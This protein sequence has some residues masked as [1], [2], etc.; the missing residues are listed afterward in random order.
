MSD[1]RALLQ[2][3]RL[4]TEEQVLNGRAGIITDHHNKLLPRLTADKTAATSS[5]RRSVEKTTRQPGND[6]SQV[7]VGEDESVVAEARAS[8]WGEYEHLMQL[9][10]RET[11]D[12]K[13][14]AHFDRVFLIS[15]LNDDGVADVR[16][17]LVTCFTVL[18]S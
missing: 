6:T 10:S 1:K 14:W 18:V 17:S 8:Q 7:G 9:A 12:L 16:V 4:L 5:S 13:G 2:C 15:A 11:R 3:I